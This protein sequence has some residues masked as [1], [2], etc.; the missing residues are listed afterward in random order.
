MVKLKQESTVYREWISRSKID[1]LSFCP[2]CFEQKTPFELTN[3]TAWKRVSQGSYHGF[4]AFK[5]PYFMKD[6]FDGFVYQ[7]DIS[8]S[9]FYVLATASLEEGDKVICRPSCLS[10]CTAQRFWRAGRPMKRWLNGVRGAESR[11]L[12]LKQVKRERYSR[13]EV[14]QMYG[15]V[16]QLC[17]LKIQDGEK[18]VIDHRVPLSRGGTDTI[19][20]VQPAHD[21]C[22]KIKKDHHQLSPD[23]YRRRRK[24]KGLR[25]S[26]P[27]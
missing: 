9:G 2:M 19:D 13:E 10:C 3:K 1:R 21:I 24:E 5:I 18:W 15:G 16:C 17:M 14:F 22:N 8:D 26:D 12:V 7:G 25:Y 23:Y 6:Y 4:L 11:A 27:D 20:N